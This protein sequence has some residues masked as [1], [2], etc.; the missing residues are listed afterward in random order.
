MSRDILDMTNIYN[1]RSTSER[2][3]VVSLNVYISM[4]WHDLKYKDDAPGTASA[5][6]EDQLINYIKII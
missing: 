2:Y 3:D 4:V 6:L 1:G 5:E